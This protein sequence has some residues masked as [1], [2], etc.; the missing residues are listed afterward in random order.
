MVAGMRAFISLI[1]LLGF[2]IVAVLLF[3]AVGGLAIWLAAVAPAIVA[4]KIT[5]PLFVALVGGAGDLAG[6][7]RQARAD[8]RGHPRARAGAPALG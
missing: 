6:L 5:L 3:A 2:F 7:A 1:M 8:A 4:L